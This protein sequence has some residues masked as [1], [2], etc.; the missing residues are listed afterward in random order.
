MFI[1]RYKRF[2]PILEWLPR[3]NKKDLSG[4]FTSGLTVAVMLIPQGM[5]YGILAGLPPIYGLYAGIVPLIIYAI[6]GTSPQLSVG[7]VALVSLLVLTGVSK[8]AEPGTPEFIQLSITVAL[9]AGIIQLLLGVFR[10]G[11]LVNFLSHPVI[12][13]FTSAAAII[14]GISQLSNL[15]GFRIENSNKIHIIILS[16]VE[17]IGKTN[18]FTL[19]IGIFGLIFIS[20]TKSINKRL[21]SGLFA[22]I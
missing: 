12:S 8:F 10:L 20:W 13:G 16:L 19:S 17:N 9:I 14:I 1:N 11:F 3:Y 18:F 6:F 5:A 22:V 2:L 21:P 7:P 15:M 4:D